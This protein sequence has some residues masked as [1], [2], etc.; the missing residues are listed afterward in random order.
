MRIDI[1][2]IHNRHRWLLY[3]HIQ[4]SHIHSIH[5]HSIGGA[6]AGRRCRCDGCG[7]CA[8]CRFP[9]PFSVMRS[10]VPFCWPCIHLISIFVCQSE[11]SFLAYVEFIRY[12]SFHQFQCINTHT[13]LVACART[14]TWFD[15]F[16]RNV[17]NLYIHNEYICKWN[18]YY[19]LYLRQYKTDIKV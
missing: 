16:G 12:V 3:F 4:L 2:S 10:A 1:N 19:V 6:S 9:C 17:H 5:T 14:R 13:A 7:F 18:M 8:N 11:R 15:I